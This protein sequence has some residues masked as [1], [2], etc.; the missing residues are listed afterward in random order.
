MS[1]A[2]RIPDTERTATMLDLLR[3]PYEN[4]RGAMSLSHVCIEEVA[5]GTGFVGASRYADLLVLSV[6]RSNGLTLDGYEI[7]ASKADLKRELADP[8]KA[9]AVA[10]YCDSWT[11][12]VWDDAVLVPGI[13]ESWGITTT[14]DGE[15]GRVLAVQRK[16]AKREP[17]VWSR[18]FVCSLVRNAYQQSPGAAYVAR[19]CLEASDKSWKSSRR[20]LRDE[21]RTSLKPL[22]VALYGAN[23]WK[24]PPEAHDPAALVKLAAERL[25][26]GTLSLDATL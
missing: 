9:E 22:A 13:P 23:D 26:Q 21:L 16:P 3:R 8:S 10:R 14:V 12:V 1:T 17:D 24:W 15:Y 7:K 6:W 4:E 5:P 11:L 19:V 25:A 20:A 2:R 18:P